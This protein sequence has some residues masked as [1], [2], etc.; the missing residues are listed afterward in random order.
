MTSEQKDAISQVLIA[1]KFNKDSFIVNEGDSASSFYIVLE[2]LL[3]LFIG[4]SEC[5]ETE[6]IYKE[7]SSGRLFWRTS[8]V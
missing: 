1:Q 8:L 3:K 4:R 5:S 6:P 7:I 2:V